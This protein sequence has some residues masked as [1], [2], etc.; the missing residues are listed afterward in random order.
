M[1]S[2]ELKLRSFF[3]L[4][5]AIC[6]LLQGAGVVSAQ[7]IDPVIMARI[8]S[9]LQKRG[10]T[11]SE[12]RVR[13]LQKGIDL[14]NI[15]PAE[16]PNYQ[17]QVT[18][19]L[20]EL[21]AEKKAGKATGA[22]PGFA[23][24]QVTDST[25]V[26][27]EALL[28]KADEAAK[29]AIQ[30]ASTKKKDSAAIYGHSLFADRTLEV[31]RTTDGAQA[32][33][34]YVLGDGDEIRITIF[35]ASQTDIQ[36]KIALDGSI[37]PVG[38]AKIF[39]KGL[40]LAQ[41]REV[42][43][44]RLSSSYSFRSDQLAVTVVTAR[45]ILVN[46]LGEVKVTGGFTLS[47]LN[48][49][50]NALSAAGGP[51]EIG[52]VRSIQLIRGNTRKNIDIYAFLNDPAAQYQ[53]D[54]QNN[55]IIFVP[56][57]K[58][59]VSIEGAVKRPMFYEMLPGESL[60]DLIK[61]A[62]D[63]K[64]DVFPDFVQIQRYVNGEQRLLEYDLQKIRSGNT[65]VVLENGDFVR[66][67]AIGKPMDQFVQIEGSVYY[68]GKYDLKSNPTL[69]SL[70]DKAKPGFEAKTDVLFIE[71]FRSDSTVEVLTLPFPGVAADKRE[72]FLQPRDVVK[73]MSQAAYRDMDTISV[74]GHVRMPFKKWFRI[75]DRITV[76]QAIKLAGGLKISA[77][78]VAYI[79]R[80]NLFNPG[81]IQYIRIQLSVADD[82]ELQAGDQLNVFDN[83]TFTNVG[84][85]R[86]FGAVKNPIGLTYDP[87]LTIRDVLTNA[88][89]FTVGAAL[90]RIEVFRTVLSPTEPSRL[91]QITLQVDSAYQVTA[92]QNFTLQP[93]DQV[94]VRLTPEFTLG[95]TVEIN[96]QVKYPGTYS[97]T[98]KQVQL[99]EVVRMAGGLLDDA[100]PL[101]SRLFRT[102]RSRGNITM[103]VQKA[104]VHAKKLEYDPILFEGDIINI[105]RRENTVTIR[106][107]GTL[108]VQYSIDSTSYFIK[109]VIYQKSRSA[110]WYVRN[111]AGGFD[112]RANR[113][114]VTVTLAN[115]QMLST[116]RALFVFRNY[117]IA[118]PG[119][120]I[121]M[122]MKP[123][124]VQPA[125]G[126]KTDWDAIV[127]RT[128]SG[129]TAMLT[130]YL[131][132][133]QLG[134]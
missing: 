29:Q 1:K 112:K 125:E 12:V 20:D 113:N 27:T 60:A 64:M 55:D 14:E 51:T 68:P 52:S 28:K 45:T 115:D 99:S 42:I 110:A 40:T 100:D 8:N 41:A 53:Y 123:P 70:L 7:T 9:E 18:A 105:N 66:I 38:V 87:S 47:A 10:L 73:V 107:T 31:F 108:M 109:N 56:V 19:V 81:E 130:L 95:R 97:L 78:P 30:V 101:G 16:L 94:V 35:G 106:G 46:V 117:P 54:L 67:K 79:F 57:G 104:L 121:S 63:V 58:L 92:P 11:E 2:P 17:Q 39:L 83:A 80:R 85:V 93:Y 86:V 62:G 24:Q 50:L 82:I 34:T 126:K 127:G 3:I 84:E 6:F 21:Q 69:K 98:S 59:L 116:K 4:I 61:Y 118:Q 119:S 129:I 36:Q 76:D 131:L 25:A 43:K 65:S 77:Y 71:R 74:A 75:S 72:I 124:K 90:N 96:G 15:P 114:S 32:P 22:Q 23:G 128:T 91:E 48:S 111:Y 33:E 44:S 102:Y 132:A 88:G 120:V 122:Q 134:L 37:Q 133:R 49:A 5:I 103:D 13:L 26:K 89:G